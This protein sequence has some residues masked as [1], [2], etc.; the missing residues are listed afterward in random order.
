MISV[1]DKKEECC[2]CTACMNICPVKAIKMAPDEEGFVY[3][4]INQELCV[5]CGRCR[6]VCQFQNEVEVKGKLEEV[7]VYAVKHKSYEIRMQSTSGGFYSALS[8]SI[9]DKSGSVFGVKFDDNFKVV[10]SKANDFYERNKYRGSKYVQSDLK[11]VFNDVQNELKQGNTVLFTGTG[12]QVAGLRKFLTDTKTSIDKLITNDVVCHGASS[13]LL[14]KDYLKFIQKKNKLS[15]YTFRDKEKG[16][17]GYNVKVEYEN[18]KIKINSADIRIFAKLFSSN[19]ILRPSCYNCKFT[20]LNRPSDVMMGD[21]WG[22]EKAMYEID[23]NRGVSLFIINTSKGKNVFEKIKGNLEVWESNTL[24]CLQPNLIRPT[25]RPQK[26]DDFWKDYYKHGFEYIAKKYAGY[27]LK[28][29][30]KKNLKTLLD[31]TGFSN[32]K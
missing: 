11:D 18:G 22:I 16:W 9:L 21:F 6:K 15:S 10:H 23:D 14:W 8:D 25:K 27:N 13:P 2:G 24:D 29:I 26:R 17:R 5:D 12:C 31:K 30:I 28:G 19:L 20:N 4:V 32:K 1:F 3:P 7:Q